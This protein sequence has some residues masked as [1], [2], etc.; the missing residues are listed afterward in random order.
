LF[1]SVA[2]KACDTEATS[3]KV[4]AILMRWLQGA[5]DRD[6]GRTKR[7]IQAIKDAAEAEEK[8]AK[9]ANEEEEEEE[10]MSFHVVD[11]NNY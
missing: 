8:A 7:T 9:A 3:V 5:R 1:V 11:F 2:V 4:K 6:G 10:E